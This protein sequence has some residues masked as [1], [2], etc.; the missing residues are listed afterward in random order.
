MEPETVNRNLLIQGVTRLG[1]YY[2]S[3]S[4][5]FPNAES[6]GYLPIS[7]MG[8]SAGAGFMTC[9]SLFPRDSGAPSIS[10][11]RGDAEQLEGSKHPSARKNK[12]RIPMDNDTWIQLEHYR[13][14]L[15][16]KAIQAAKIGGYQ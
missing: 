3:V 12:N 1:D 16:T 4:I 6:M 9:R 8:S 10:V 13:N 7:T 11:R 15:G 2:P 5:S 14:I